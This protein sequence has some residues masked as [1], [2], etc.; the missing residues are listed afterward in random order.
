MRRR[1]VLKSV[2]S[3][4]LHS[5]ISR[6]NDLDGYWALG[7]LFLY[8]KRLG[9]TSVTLD[10]IGRSIS[11]SPKTLSSIYQPPN[12][13]LLS[14][15]YGRMLLHVL[16]K[17]NAPLAWAAKALIT[18]EFDRFNVVPRYLPAGANAR[19]YECTL[20]LVDDLSHE[21]KLKLTGWCWPHDPEIEY[22]ST[23]A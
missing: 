16:A 20:L 8:A 21:H 18:I 5:F 7:K 10:L 15:R 1:V 12:V 2:G 6:N 13:E 22:R 23:R 4:L 17:R 9:T 3:G 14:T 19:P 11:P